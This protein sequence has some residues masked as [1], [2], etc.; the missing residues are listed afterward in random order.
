LSSQEQQKLIDAGY[1]I[2]LDPDNILSFYATSI[3]SDLGNEV[4]EDRINSSKI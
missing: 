4:M 1:N 3:D 2:E